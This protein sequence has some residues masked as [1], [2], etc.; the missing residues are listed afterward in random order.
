MLKTEISDVRVRSTEQLMTPLDLVRELPIT[1]KAQKT[2][3]DGR[4]GIEAVLSGDDKRFIVVTGPCSIHDEKA[5]LEFAERLTKL[6]EKVKDRI[7]MVMRVYFEKPRTTVGWKGLLYDPHLDDS[8]DIYTGLKRGRKLLLQIAEMGMPAATEFLDPIVPQYLADL[9]A[10]AAIGARTTESQTHRQM[11]SG[12]SMPV[13]FKNGTD[14]STQTAVDAIVS[15]RSKHGFLGID[16]NGRTA[17]VHTTGNPYGHIVLR[18]GKDGPNFDAA[19]VAEAQKRLAAAKVPDKVIVDCSHG[20]CNKDHTKMNI[21][22]RSVVEQRV[23]GNTGLCGVMLESNLG[24]G[25]QKLNGGPAGLKYGVSI[26][27]ACID[28]AE[29]EQLITWAHGVLA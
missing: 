27:D 29:N 8:F 12:L 18:G 16:V 3:I 10:W 21:G 13:G 7:F 1:P 26:T 22:F 11:A 14:G 28:W 17:V 6:N 23:A 9:V 2:V 5:A 19:S 24:A 4:R 15:S 20:N 25:N